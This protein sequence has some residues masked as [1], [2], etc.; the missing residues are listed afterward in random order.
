[1]RGYGYRLSKRLA[2][3]P[4]TGSLPQ[5]HVAQCSSSRSWGRE[6]EG[7]AGKSTCSL[8]STG[9]FSTS[10]HQ[11]HLHKE[12]TLLC[13]ASTWRVPP[14]SAIGSPLPHFRDSLLQPR[15]LLLPWHTGTRLEEAALGSQRA[16][17]VLGR[18]RGV[19]VYQASAWGTGSTFYIIVYVP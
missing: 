18:G 14:L 2:H 8:S 17:S 13:T 11:P 9:R 1:M 19:D 15:L 6:E 12:T 10:A 4:A 7:G 3:A 5:R 16:L